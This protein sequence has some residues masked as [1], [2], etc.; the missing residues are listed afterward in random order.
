MTCFMV[1]RS[2]VEAHRLANKQ[3]AR[4]FGERSVFSKYP[5]RAILSV[6]VRRKMAGRGFQSWFLASVVGS[7]N[8]VGVC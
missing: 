6:I 3:N 8:L 5:W 4:V 1:I 2:E 7:T